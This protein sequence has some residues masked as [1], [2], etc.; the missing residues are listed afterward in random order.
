[1]FSKVHVE[2]KVIFKSE[3]FSRDQRHQAG[4]IVEYFIL[5]TH[6]RQLHKCI[7]MRVK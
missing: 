6:T 4:K 3:R 2:D 1:M 7:Y 5:R